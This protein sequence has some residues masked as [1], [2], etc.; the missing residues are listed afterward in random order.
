M[1]CKNRKCKAELPEGAR[2][3]PACGREQEPKRKRSKRGN[4]GGT[5]SYRPD[6]SKPYFVYA[7]YNRNSECRRKFIGSFSTKE[8]AE[9]AL[10][11]FSTVPVDRYSMTLEQLH[12]EWMSLK[13]YKLLSKD[14]QNNHQSSWY[15]L[16]TI[17][18][19][20]VRDL[21]TAQ[22][23]T[24]IDHYEVEHHQEGE[25]G[26]LLYLDKKGKRTFEKTS[27]PVMCPGLSYSSL[28]KIKCLLTA[29]YDYAIKCDIVNKNY[30]EF[31]ELPK[32]Q[33][34]A[35]DRFTDLEVSKIEKA[36]GTVPFA[37]Y[38]LCMC[39]TGFR[40][41][42]FLSLDKFSI[43]EEDGILFLVGGIKTDAGRDRPVPVHSKID[44]I[45]KERIAQNGKTLF[46]KPDGSSFSD[47]YFREKYY[48]PALE[49][50]GV[51]KL[52][53]H[54]TRRTFSTKGSAA[55]LKDED[56]IALMGHTDIKVDRESYIIQE[57]KTLKKAIEKIS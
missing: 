46:C 53:P 20:K 33:K 40:I 1:I 55:G 13:Q 4:N 12:T 31:V 50:I 29:M 54:A 9:Q 49:Q 8:L 3:C 26:K 37:D 52:T 41:T 39:Y 44:S 2:F 16:R 47:K 57:A 5:I 28:S 35:K 22:M 19:F 21:R 51:R 24:V 10:R 30:A 25:G 36:V 43:R 6:R 38:I 15:K 34:S 14:T 7:P 18:D 56:L 48:Y 17:K 27:T 42:E 11:D 23:Q 32:K 45:V